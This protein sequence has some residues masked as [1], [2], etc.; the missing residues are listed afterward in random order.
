MNALPDSPLVAEATALVT[1]LLSGELLHHSLRAF[2]LG[3]AYA[4]RRAMRFDEEGLLL[5]ALFHD[6]GLTD[7]LG[8]PT[9]PF[10]EVGAGRVRALLA[11]H[12]DAARGARLAEAIAL[13]MQLL[14][15]W[16]RGEVAG[17]LHVGAWMEATGWRRGAVG[18]ERIGEIERALPRGAF[19]GQFRGRVRR[20]LGSIRACVGLMFP[21]PQA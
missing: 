5:A 16:S 10:T 8:D 2:H 6:L 14:P 9:R 4:E 17:L 7:A 18:R 20:S 3:R 11:A 19:D 12:G 13:H 1:P 21:A 15:R